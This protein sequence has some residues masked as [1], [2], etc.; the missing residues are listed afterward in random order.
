MKQ[1]IFFMCCALIFVASVPKAAEVCPVPVRVCE[2][3]VMLDGFMTQICRS[4]TDE[5]PQTLPEVILANISIR[6]GPPLFR[7]DNTPILEGELAKYEIVF[8]GMSEMIGPGV[9]E[10]DVPEIT[11]GAEFKIRVI[12]QW[13]RKSQYINIPLSGA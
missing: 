13:G 11:P 7:E 9:T 5:T 1:T 6:I 4:V 10:W 8:D 3:A 12:D 2:E